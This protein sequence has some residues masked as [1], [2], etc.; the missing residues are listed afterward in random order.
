MLEL[1]AEKIY[2]YHEGEECFVSIHMHCEEKKL[3]ITK[4][5]CKRNY[6]RAVMKAFSRLVPVPVGEGD[7]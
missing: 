4:F 7:K 6:E 2:S 1:E 5:K 3:H